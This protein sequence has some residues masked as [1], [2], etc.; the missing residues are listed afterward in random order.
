MAQ[1]AFAD[2]L[3]NNQRSNLGLTLSIPLFN[4]F[5]VRNNVNTSKINILN[6]E[7]NLDK[8]KKELLNEIQ[9]AYYNAVAAQRKYQSSGESVEAST[10][11][12]QYAQEKYDAGK[13]SVFEL[14]EAKMKMAQSLAELLQSK[15]EFIF[16]TKILDF[17]RGEKITL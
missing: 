12:Y 1:L 6:Q 2:Q 17:Y 14:N 3:K 16:R 10:T 4:R 7:L 15:Y 9:Q 8:S 11:S 13:A 5:R